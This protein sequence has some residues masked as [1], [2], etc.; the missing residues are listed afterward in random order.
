MFGL[1]IGPRAR[2]AAQ[3]SFLEPVARLDTSPLRELVRRNAQNVPGVYRM[4]GARGDVLYVGKSRTLRTRL[5]SYFRLPW[6]EHRHARMLRETANIEWEVM[7]SEFAALLREARL[8]R[9]HLPTYNKRGARPLDQ[10]W[11]IVVRREPVPRLR[12]QRASTVAGSR[13]GAGATVIGPFAHRAPL[14]SAVRVLNDALGLRDCADRVPMVLRDAGDFF[15]D[16]PRYTRTPGCHRYET[17][18]C[19]GPCVAACSHDEYL[20]QISRAQQF[21][22]GISDEPQVALER[23]MAVASAALSF[24]RAGWLRDRLASLET[25]NAQLARVREALQRPSFAYRVP[26]TVGADWLYLVRE[27]RVIGNA[28]VGDVNGVDRLLTLE[29]APQSRATALTVDALEE[30]TLLEH[31]FRT[32]GEEHLRTAPTVR[33][34][35]Q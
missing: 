32:R 23:E 3:L 33:A 13:A 2:P 18:R 5:L 30:L 4:I 27:G 10:W 1:P 15:A 12:V 14:I 29:A 26:S 31:W 11:V 17:R 35:L 34:L 20:T 19:L 24:E 9:A 16:D 6:P 25:L 21:I 7:P 8:I 22:N 28:S